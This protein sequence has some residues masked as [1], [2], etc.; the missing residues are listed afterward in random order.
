MAQSSGYLLCVLSDQ[1][2]SLSPSYPQL[3]LK[4]ANSTNL[5]QVTTLSPVFSKDRTGTS[6][7][8]LIEHLLYLGS[9]HILVYVSKKRAPSW[10][11]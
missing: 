9:L 4:S 6:Q 2:S 10:Y 3:A 11:R 7:Q 1:K 5:C 8:L